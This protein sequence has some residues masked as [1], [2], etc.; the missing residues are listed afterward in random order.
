LFTVD[1]TY[2][3]F[4]HYIK[5]DGKW[6]CVDKGDDGVMYVNLKNKGYYV[7]AQSSGYTKGVLQNG[8]R[9]SSV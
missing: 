4:Y 7:L 2:E 3:G 1:E 9:L 8:E 6:V 5:L